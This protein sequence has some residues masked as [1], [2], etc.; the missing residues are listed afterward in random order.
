M[1]YYKSLIF[2]LK[3]NLKTSNLKINNLKQLQSYRIFL[4]V[5]M[6]LNKGQPNL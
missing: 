3:L 4:L 5:D 6:Q 2:N 1:N